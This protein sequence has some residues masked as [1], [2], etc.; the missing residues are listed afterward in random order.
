[1]QRYGHRDRGEGDISDAEVA[2]THRADKA[3]RHRAEDSGRRERS[4]V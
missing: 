4:H 1:M 3:E 2:G